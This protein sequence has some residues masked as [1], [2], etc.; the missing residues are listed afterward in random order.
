MVKMDK[1]IK[2]VSFHLQW[3]ITERCNFKCKHCYTQSDMKELSTRELF[4]V[5]EQYM[6]LIRTWELDK[7]NR[8]RKLSLSGGEPL[9]RRDFFKL[10]EEIYKNRK[11]FTSVMVMS[12]GSK[13]NEKVAKRLKDSGVSWVQISVDGLEENNDKIRGEGNFRKTIKGIEKL[14][15]NGLPVGISMT[16]HKDNLG[17]MEGLINL[18][19]VMG[20]KK[21]GIGRVVPIGRGKGLRILEPLETKKFYDKVM[22]LKREWTGKDVY[23]GTHCSDSL[24]FIE[25]LGYKTHGCS[26]GYD[27]FSILPNGD[28]VPCRRLPVKVGNVLEKSLID[29]WYTSDF[30]WKLR[31]KGNVALCK[32]CELFT[33][34]FGGARC[35]AYGYF[36]DFFV[37]DPQCWKLFKT[38]PRK[39]KSDSKV[40]DLIVFNENYTENFDPK[41]YFEGMS[42][43]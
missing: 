14:I 1:L 8:V 25:D 17:D 7:N 28:V 41:T 42:K 37:P 30:L 6:D 11:M 13:I 24:W 40:D 26:T 34:C 18:C 3:H 29:I 43:V 4:I 33:K 22:K 20:I 39:I 38:L 36:N 27:S 5:L 19:K 12:N 23:I 21:I 15:G 16:I 10:L 35:V 31:N 32:N 9:L 2:P